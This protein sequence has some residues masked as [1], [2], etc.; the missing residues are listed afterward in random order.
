MD[1]GLAPRGAPRNDEDASNCLSLDSISAAAPDLPVALI[2]RRGARLIASPNHGHNRGHP[3]L[4]KEGRFAIVTNV[5]RGERWTLLVRETSDLKADG[6][7][8]WF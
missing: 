8:V 3:V 4:D 1:S 5:G 2:G 7:V 6:E